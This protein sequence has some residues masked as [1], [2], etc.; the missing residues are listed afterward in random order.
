MMVTLI[1]PGLFGPVPLDAASWPRVPRLERLVA[2]ATS[3]P[4]GGRDAAAVCLNAFG[5]PGDPAW[6]RPTAPFACWGEEPELGADGYCLHA[7]PVH[8]KPDGE[9]L[10]LFAGPEL[11]LDQDEAN[12][13][14]TDFNQHFAD[15]GLLLEAPHPSRWYL[16]SERC[17]DL[18]AA[19]LER[20]L[21]G[22]VPHDAPAGTDARR[23]RAL[24]TETQMLFHQHPVNERRARLRQPVISGIWTWGGG[25]R[26]APPEGAA[27][28][29]MPTLVVGNPPLMRGLARWAGSR[30]EPLTH[31]PTCAHWDGERVVVQWD[32]LQDALT[33]R[34]LGAWL[35]AVV[36]LNT[37]LEELETP[38]RQGRLAAI[39]IEP[40]LETAYR[41]ERRHLHRFWR[42]SGWSARLSHARA[43]SALPDDEETRGSGPG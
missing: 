37:W 18:Q 14:T 12:A 10:L 32:A 7:D 3:M 36:D 38:L 28:G 41:V 30:W 39:Q 40:C 22:A 5:L 17:L 26:P 27:Q 4:S 33:A 15:Q 29:S 42:R 34:D 24:L 43:H 31:R 20:L 16:R 25:V 23:W 11:G 2:R 35:Q 21:G 9:R 13:L 19:P 6:E 8:L 1:C